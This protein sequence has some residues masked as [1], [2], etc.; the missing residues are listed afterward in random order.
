MP[1][2]YTRHHD[3]VAR[4]VGE[5]AVLTT[6]MELMIALHTHSARLIGAWKSIL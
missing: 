1:E 5:L 6:M 3:V 4:L 2:D